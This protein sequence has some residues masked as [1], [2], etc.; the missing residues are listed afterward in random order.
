MQL[1]KKREKSI[2]INYLYI[3]TA[4]ICMQNEEKNFKLLIK[5]R[6]TKKMS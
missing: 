1:T 5:S 3:F 6:I 4:V 2:I